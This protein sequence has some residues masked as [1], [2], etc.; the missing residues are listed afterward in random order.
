[1]SFRCFY[2]LTLGILAACY[3]RASNIT[4][5]PWTDHQFQPALDLQNRDLNK[6]PLRNSMEPRPRQGSFHSYVSAHL[7]FVTQPN[8]PRLECSEAAARGGE[9]VSRHPW[10]QPSLFSSTQCS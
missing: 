9:Q 4:H 10:T 3:Q 8:R 6:S 1:S 5:L 2:T 7:E